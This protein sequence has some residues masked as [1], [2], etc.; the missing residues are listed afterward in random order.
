MQQ[1]SIGAILY[2]LFAPLCCGQGFAV[3]IAKP[4]KEN[5]RVRLYR[6]IGHARV[7]CVSAA[8]L[9]IKGAI[10]CLSLSLLCCLVH[11]TDVG[12]DPSGPKGVAPTDVD[13]N[14]WLLLQP[15]SADDVTASCPCTLSCMGSLL[16]DSS[17]EVHSS[18]EDLDVAASCP[19]TLSCM[20]SLFARLQ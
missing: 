9:S 20:G 1:S 15:T 10:M 14:P 4:I 5:A 12:F 16:P 18:D 19:S 8:C 7:R 6:G 11:D 17:D 2:C 13:K 3:C